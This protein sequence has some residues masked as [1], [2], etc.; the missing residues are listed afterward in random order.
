LLCIEHKTEILGSHS[1][2]D[3]SCII[4]G[5]DGVHITNLVIGVSKEL[6]IHTAWR[7]LLQ[8]ICFCQK[9][10]EFSL[11]VAMNVAYFS[12]SHVSLYT[13]DFS[14]RP[15]AAQL[16]GIRVRIELRACMSVPCGFLMLY[17]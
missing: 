15:A 12:I 9:S 10:F 16:L 1:V 11:N 8:G 7:D 4:L 6:R 17:R 2:E 3:V 14:C 5:Y 13:F